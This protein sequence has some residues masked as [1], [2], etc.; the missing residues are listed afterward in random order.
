MAE[1]IKFLGVDYGAKMAGTTSVCYKYGEFLRIEQSEK[2]KDADL[3]LSSLIYKLK[4]EYIFIDAPLSLPGVYTEPEKYN[5]YFYRKCDREAGAMSPMFL[6]GLTARA[7][8]LK[9]SF[10]KIYFV[11]T[12]PKLRSIK[13]FGND[14]KKVHIIE[15]NRILR[16]SGLKFI[17]EPE[18]MHQIDSVLAWLVGNDFIDGKSHKIGDDEA[19]IN[20]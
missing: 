5:D 3:F 15:L 18:N 17:N 11:E 10:K 19:Y 16:T 7:M 2:K 12:Y 6:G 20:Y 1:Q 4:P 9:N 8:K 14:Y 13:I